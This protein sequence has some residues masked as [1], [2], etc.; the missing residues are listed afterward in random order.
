MIRPSKGR[1]E[2]LGV[3]F[4]GIDEEK[5]WSRD[6]WQSFC[7]TGTWQL[8]VYDGDSRSRMTALAGPLNA[9]PNDDRGLE[10]QPRSNARW[11]G[12]FFRNPVVDDKTVRG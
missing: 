7:R 10:L 9:K 3:G 5:R 11:L 8:R 6:G 4:G 2:S 1:G 12:T